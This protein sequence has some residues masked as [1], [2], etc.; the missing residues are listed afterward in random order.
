[1]SHVTGIYGHVTWQLRNEDGTVAAEG[2]GANLVTTTGDRMYA[3]R[4]AGIASPLAAPTGMKLGTGTTNPAK[5][6][7]GAALITYL[8]DSQQG[9][10]SGYPSAAAQGS[11]WRVTY[12]VTYPT[13]KAT[14]GS[15][16]TEAVIVNETLTDAT[17]AAGS[18]IARILLSGV[19]AKGSTQTLTITWTHDLLGA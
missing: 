11:G 15:A 6:G 12:K 10:D 17:S 18:T 13:G 19:T 5:T 16:I 4:G 7:A 9:F 14:T 2:E 1:M 8:S 3:G